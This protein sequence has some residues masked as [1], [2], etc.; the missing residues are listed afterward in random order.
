MSTEIAPNM[1]LPNWSEDGTDITVPLA[2]FPK[3]GADSADAT[4]GDTKWLLH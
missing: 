4:T 3:M 2:T 1:W